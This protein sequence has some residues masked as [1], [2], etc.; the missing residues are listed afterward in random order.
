MR[1]EMS[2]PEFKCTKCEKPVTRPMCIKAKILHVLQRNRTCRCGTDSPGSQQKPTV[3]SY[4]HGN[5]T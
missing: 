5:E 1:G 3:G 2:N 4:E